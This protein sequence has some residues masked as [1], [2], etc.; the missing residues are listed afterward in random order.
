MQQKR[1]AHGRVL[2]LPFPVCKQHPTPKYGM[3]DWR[4]WSSKP[5]HVTGTCE[6]CRHLQTQCGSRKPDDLTV[7][8]SIVRLDAPQAAARAPAGASDAAGPSGHTAAR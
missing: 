7:V 8:V 1:D 4:L 6:T 3:A 2:S 5:R